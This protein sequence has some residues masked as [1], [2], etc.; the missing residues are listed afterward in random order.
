MH[1]KYSRGFSSVGEIGFDGGNSGCCQIYDPCVIYE[2]SRIFSMNSGK[3]INNDN[4]WFEYKKLRILMK[5]LKIF[6]SSR[7]F[8]TP[9]QNDFS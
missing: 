6:C 1:G 4:N 9:L 7:H 5:L 2:V 8:K 3:Q